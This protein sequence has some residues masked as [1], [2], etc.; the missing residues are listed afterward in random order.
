M[1]EIV[2]IIL[3]G[4][5]IREM[6]KAKGLS[7][8]KYIVIMVLLWVGL[9]FT[10]GTL[11]VVITQNELM[12]YPFAIAG[13]ITGAIIGYQIAKRAKPAKEMPLDVLDADLD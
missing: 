13:A 3:L 4:K 11:G 7:P 9:E 5:K 8:T 2:G 10:L 1:L 12:A 6:V